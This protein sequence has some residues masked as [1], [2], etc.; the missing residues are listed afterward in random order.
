M[1]FVGGIDSVR[2]R[3]GLHCKPQVDGSQNRCTYSLGLGS[4]RLVCQLS[5]CKFGLHGPGPA[6]P[7]NVEV[8]ELNT[9]RGTT[10]RALSKASDEIGLVKSLVHDL[11]AKSLLEEE[12]VT[13]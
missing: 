6:L 10:A 2:S 4:V 3:R 12:K 1:C 13:M 5:V 7:P 11:R 9:V 8:A